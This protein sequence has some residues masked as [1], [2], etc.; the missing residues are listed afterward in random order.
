MRKILRRML[1][2]IGQRPYLAPLVLGLVGL[3]EIVGS[4]KTPATAAAP[5]PLVS[6]HGHMEAR[7]GEGRV[8]VLPLR[9]TEVAADVVGV[10]SSVKVT[11]HFVNPYRRPIE[12]VYVFPLPHRAAIHAMTMR[13]GERLI[14]A[15]VKRRE[16]ARASYERAKKQGK[17][18]ALL[19]QERDNIFTQTVANILP[20]ESIRVELAY[21]EELVPRD[22]S[23]DFVFPMVVGPRYMG[24]SAPSVAPPTGT[25]W[26]AD[27]ARV[28]DASRVSP[29]LLR[30]GTRPGNDIALTL[31]INAGLPI[32]KIAVQ[33]HRSSLQRPSS[34]LAIIALDPSDRIPN[35]D[36]VVRYRL[37]GA[38]PRVT[39]LAARHR[40][41]G[42]HFLLMVQPK[43][44][45]AAVD[46]APREYVFVVD[47]S[48]SMSGTPLDRIKQVM[49]RCLGGLRPDD[50]LQVIQFA[51]DASALAPAPLPPSRDNVSRALA[52]VEA[53]SAG[54]GTE[55]IPALEL[56]LRAP[57]DPRRARI[58]L[59]MTDGYIGYEAEVLRFIRENGRG[60]SVFALGVGSSVNRYLVDGMA[61]IGG[62]EP[63]VLLNDQPEA[64]VVRRFFRTV[65]RPALTGITLDWGGLAVEQATPVQDLFADRPVVVSGRYREGGRGT[66]TVR[67]FLAGKPYEQKLDLSLPATPGSGG[68]ALAYLWAR[69]RIGALMDRF[70]TEPEGAPAIQKEVT[71]LALRYSLM[72]KWTSF[73]AVDRR[74]RNPSGQGATAVVP[75]PLPDGVGE[76]AA[77]PAAFAPA[78]ISVRGALSTDQFVP[79]DPEVQI[80]APDDTLRV[81]L[82]FPTGEVKAC[83]RDPRTGLWR[84][85]FLIPE[86]TPDGVYAIRVLLERAGGVQM[87]RRLRYQVDGAEPHVR[88]RLAPERAAPGEQ[89]TLTL[90]PQP[91]GPTLESAAATTG[92]GDIGDPG[93]AGRVMQEIASARVSLPGAELGL[94]LR[95]Q[96]DGGWRLT[97]AAPRAPGRHA[98]TVVVRDP[99]GNKLRRTLWLQVR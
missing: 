56:A 47:T 36:F 90:V 11:Q 48:G 75:L 63:F 61:R 78:T 28:K 18:A 2:P 22:G 70:D 13:V 15:R 82:F 46:L 53:M 33:S 38:A 72:S 80:R 9:H 66:V 1:A 96:A 68:T 88:L 3:F 19:E 40:D 17:T 87:V 7:L 85:S 98:L 77:P 32:E 60:A 92:E 84:A 55:L 49:Q 30:P 94:P 41:L 57:R 6:S 76:Q 91:L 5:P 73:V 42:G 58:V 93:F 54:G 79:G 12:A 81:T 20:G 52:F 44:R 16:A 31:R 59:F 50:R 65:S 37:A 83:D 74:I 39:A 99:A 45:P 27:S 62:G 21:V 69:R 25:G 8:A 14:Q 29:P 4:E 95:R 10:M 71:A 86:Q 51:G 67:G 24:E 89:V 35:K 26:A 34:D 23:Y 43:A 97:F 64:P